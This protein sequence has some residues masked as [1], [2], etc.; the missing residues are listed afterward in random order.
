M[1]CGVTL[2]IDVFN[3]I[4]P[5]TFIFTTRCMMQCYF[6]KN[7]ICSPYPR[8]CRLLKGTGYCMCPFLCFLRC[9]LTGCRR[10]IANKQTWNIFLMLMSTVAPYNTLDVGQFHCLLHY[11]HSKLLEYFCVIRLFFIFIYLFLKNTNIYFESAGPF[12]TL[13]SISSKR[14]MFLF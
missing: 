14:G 8:M 2:I 13:A 4:F 7:S 6:N 12:Y 3:S 5:W 11:L 1:K 9:G 10:L